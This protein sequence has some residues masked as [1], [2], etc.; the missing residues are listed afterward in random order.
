MLCRSNAQGAL[1][2]FGQV[3]SNRLEDCACCVHHFSFFPFSR[4]AVI[5]S[6]LVSIGHEVI[7]R[8]SVPGVNSQQSVDTVGTMVY[9]E[10]Q[11]STSGRITRRSKPMDV[12]GRETESMRHSRELQQAR[13]RE[14]D[15]AR[16]ARAKKQAEEDARFELWFWKP[17]STSR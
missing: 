8:E 16:E 1:I 7:I 9:L 15:L 6:R 17:S 2:V 4:H 5:L 10:H 14:A 13:L 11:R 12:F 3:K